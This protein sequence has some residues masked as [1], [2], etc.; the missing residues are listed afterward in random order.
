[1]LAVDKTGT[2]TTGKPVLTGLDVLPDAAAWDENAL[3]GLAASLEA[4]SEHP[5]A[6]ASW[7]PPRNA[8]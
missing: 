1:M 2:L 6:H 5:L 3:L 8:N 4:R 7:P